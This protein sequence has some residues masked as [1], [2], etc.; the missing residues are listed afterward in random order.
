MRFYHHAHSPPNLQPWLV[1]AVA[2]RWN[3]LRKHA[4]Q[5]GKNNIAIVLLVSPTIFVT[6]VNRRYTGWVQSRDIRL[7]NGKRNGRH[8]ISRRYIRCSHLCA[9]LC[10]DQHEFLRCSRINRVVCRT[11]SAQ[12]GWI[13]SDYPIT[14]F[15]I[16]VLPHN[17]S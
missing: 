7:F 6:F 15:L 8:R 9:K 2:T 11:S 16:P 13:S 5:N 14:V 17:N 4:E 3:C 1:R 10:L 12:V